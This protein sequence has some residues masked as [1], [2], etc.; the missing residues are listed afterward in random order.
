MRLDPSKL[1][2]LTSIWATR[3]TAEY[4][5]ELRRWL[6]QNADQPA[7]A[8]RL[9]EWAIVQKKPE[10]AVDWAQKAV[11]WDPSG[12]AYYTLARALTVAGRRKEA[13]EALST[14]QKLLTP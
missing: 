3:S 5:L 13:S 4:G 14:A 8:I 7:G 9:S 12:P 11:D 10:E 1:V 2:R 6:E